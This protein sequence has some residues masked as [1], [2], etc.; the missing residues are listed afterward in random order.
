MSLYLP[1]QKLG[2]HSNEGGSSNKFVLKGR[3]TGTMHRGHTW[4]FRAESHDTMMAWYEDIKALTEKTPEERTQF[5]RSHSQ[6]RS[7][8]QSSRRSASSDGLDEDDDEPFSAKQEDVNPGP[9]PELVTRRSQ[10]GGRFP[11]D[12]QV[13]AQ[14][15]LQT[16]QSPSSVSSGPEQHSS[17][18]QV[19]AAAGALPGADTAA[20]A[21]E[22][23]RQDYEHHVGYGSNGQTPIEDIS[24]QAAIANRQA[25]YDGVNPY[26]SEPLQHAHTTPHGS[27][28]HHGQGVYVAPIT[29]P[30]TFEEPVLVPDTGTGQPSHNHQ[31]G[32]GSYSDGAYQITEP[33]Q[34]YGAEQAEKG[35][36]EGIHISHVP[37]GAALPL[38]SE[39]DTAAHARFVDASLA[40]NKDN[41]P[42]RPSEQ[43]TNSTAT[44]SNLPI[45]GGYPKT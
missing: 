16:P 31:E 32:K 6:R 40:N 1:D 42:V 25:H 38:F 2:S 33:G 9:R 44:I 14:R 28:S 21:A 43:R 36:I 13:N 12:I 20:Y 26:T 11:S 17:D 39:A 19:I 24:S 22:G 4:V 45:P 18:A 10:P 30:Q 23:T 15:G 3:Q 35:E 27:G 34:M 29:V 37:N 8:S 7:M 5:V 41:K